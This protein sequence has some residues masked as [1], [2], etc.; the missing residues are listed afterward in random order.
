MAASK[1]LA[2][3]QP[4][5]MDLGKPAGRLL[6]L[7]LEVKTPDPYVVTDK[8]TI[9]PPTKKTSARLDELNWSVVT[10]Q[11]ILQEA[12]RRN[13]EPRPNVTDMTDE[14]AAVAV[15]AW[16]N[17]ALAAG[18]LITELREKVSD[19]TTEW[20]RVFFGD[21]YDNLQ[22]FFDDKPKQL[23][24]RFVDDI[25]SDFLNTNEPED[26]VCAECGHVL[27]EDAAGNVSASST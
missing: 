23:W 9:A 17:R 8:I 26:G 21:Q 24:D 16:E 12:I 3:V 13:M 19:D 15:Q 18:D 25:R 11:A 1:K 2:A 20:N 5:L 22:A 14:D 6:E 7:T 10:N 27:D 4:T